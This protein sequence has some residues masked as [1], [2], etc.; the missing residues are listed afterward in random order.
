MGARGWASHPPGPAEPLSPGGACG[1][2]NQ[3]P[4]PS[5][6][7]WGGAPGISQVPRGAAITTVAPSQASRRGSWRPQEVSMFTDPTCSRAG[8]RPGVCRTPRRID[9]HRGAGARHPPA[10]GSV[11]RRRARS[12]GGVT[13]AHSLRTHGA[14]TT[15]E[16]PSLAH[17]HRRNVN[18]VPRL[19]R[20]GS[21]GRA[22]T[23]HTRV[24]RHRQLRRRN[25]E[26]LRRTARRFRG[27]ERHVIEAIPRRSQ[28]I[29]TSD[30]RRVEIERIVA[31]R[32]HGKRRHPN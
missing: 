25:A 32:Q 11:R 7:L 3:A 24:T 18:S 15:D 30:R 28:Q 14:G 1:S 13:R 6:P 20:R 31:T 2:D 9:G 12:T 5:A 21:S 27:V 22:E 10:L 26:S 17:Q 29:H 4:H 19:R 23:R 8:A 16:S